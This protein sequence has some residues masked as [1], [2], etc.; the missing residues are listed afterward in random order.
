MS[1]RTVRPMKMIV[2]ILGR[3]QG[4]AFVRLLTGK[5]IF[6]HHQCVGLGTATSDMM[7]MLGLGTAE[8]DVLL[9]IGPSDIVD[10]AL[11]ELSDSLGSGGRGKGR[12]LVFS[13]PLT[14]ISSLAAAGI[15]ASAAP[16]ERMDDTMKPESKSSLI[17][18][19]VN[20]GYTDAVMDTA[21]KKGASGGTVIRARWASNEQFAQFY[22]ITL[23]AE[24]E[25]VAI[26]VPNDLRN[27]MME[28]INLNHGLK[29][30][31]HGV[32]CSLAV[33]K[34]FKLA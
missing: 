30:D 31:A 6:F 14:G 18:V 25:V 12:G 24:K 34:A 13:L 26:L 9:S 1:E 20:Q 8:K 23:Q 33:D 32:V 17:L 5:H 27:Q 29:T 7:D 22:G 11:Y 21:K 28:A 16:E 10:R 2:S 19:S 3:G 4:N 15:L